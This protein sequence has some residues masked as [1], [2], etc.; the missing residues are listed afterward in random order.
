M[1]ERK[2][3]EG[4]TKGELLVMGTTKTEVGNQ[5]RPGGKEG[6]KEGLPLIHLNWGLLGL[7]GRNDRGRGRRR[8]SVPPSPRSGN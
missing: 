2:R 7:I 6:R 8:R 1:R 4:G 5:F 3:E